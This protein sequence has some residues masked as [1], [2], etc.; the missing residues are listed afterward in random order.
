MLCEH[1]K[2]GYT[3]LREYLLR[4]KWGYTGRREDL[5]SGKFRCSGSM[6]NGVIHICGSI[7]SGRNGVILVGGRIF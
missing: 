3:D 1:D 6:T 2:W 7:W 5:L 4:A